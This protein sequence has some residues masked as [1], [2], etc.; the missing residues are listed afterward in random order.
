MASCPILYSPHSKGGESN[1]L[2]IIDHWL[3][4]HHRK[5]YCNMMLTILLIVYQLFGHWQSFSDNTYT[6]YLHFQLQGY[7][8]EVC[9]FLNFFLISIELYTRGESAFKQQKSFLPK[10]LEG[11]V[12]G[13][14]FYREFF[15]DGLQNN[16]KLGP[17]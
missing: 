6:N 12:M 15:F 9:F 17:E 2:A 1:L 3:R 13:F 5:N 16:R 14:S 8:L 7:E 10:C 4:K 11:T